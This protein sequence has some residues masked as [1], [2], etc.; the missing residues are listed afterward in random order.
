MLAF[1]WSSALPQTQ[2]LKDAWLQPQ[3]SVSVAVH[4]LSTEQVCAGG[5]IAKEK[6]EE[7]RSSSAGWLAIY[8]ASEA[9]KL[10]FATSPLHSTTLQ[11]QLQNVFVQTAK[12]ICLN[13]KM[14]LSKLELYL[15]NL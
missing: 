7:R 6:G 15:S 10:R 3:I 13:C 5:P 9:L 2:D 1:K 11:P 4:I 12:C 14:Y 8:N